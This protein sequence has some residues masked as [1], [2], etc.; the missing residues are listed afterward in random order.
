MIYLLCIFSLLLGAVLGWV[1]AKKL[2]L[3]DWLDKPLDAHGLG[4]DDITTGEELLEQLDE[5]E[6]GEIDDDQKEMIANIVEFDEV[7]AGDIMTHRTDFAAIEGNITCREAVRLALDSGHSRMPVYDRDIDHI[8][9]ILYSKDLLQLVEQPHRMEQSVRHLVHPASFVPESCPASQLL[10]DFKGNHTQIAVV[11]DEYGGTAG[12]VSLE[13]VLEEIVGDIQDE[14]DNEEA[15]IEQLPDGFLC[16]GSA[17]LEDVFAAFGRELPAKA[18]EEEFDTAGGLV[19]D[20]LGRIPEPG[21]PASV[22]WGGLRFTAAQ[23]GDKCVEK[24]KVTAE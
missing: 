24:V 8:I 22:S 21:E 12:L 7:T 19:S 6:S 5:V 1:G 14:Y 17:H 2:H 9:G 16:E 13:D 20:L 3:P 4:N 23:I 15:E 11:V 18:A 10:A